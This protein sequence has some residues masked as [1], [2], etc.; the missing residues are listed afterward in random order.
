MK[1]PIFDYKLTCLIVPKIIFFIIFQVNCI[2]LYLSQKI[3]GSFF[4]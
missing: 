3:Q 4:R 1:F 2:S